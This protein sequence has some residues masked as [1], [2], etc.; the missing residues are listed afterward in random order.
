[1]FF[2]KWHNEMMEMSVSNRGFLRYN[3]CDHV[4][5]HIFLEGHGGDGVTFLSPWH[6]SE[7]HLRRISQQKTEAGVL[8]EMSFS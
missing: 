3:R 1:M 4:N 8:K 2:F 5:E 7:K 6:H